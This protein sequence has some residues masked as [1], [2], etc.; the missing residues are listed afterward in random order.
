MNSSSIYCITVSQSFCAYCQQTTL[1]EKNKQLLS[2]LR[3]THD[4]W[5]SLQSHAS[6]SL[7]MLYFSSSSCGIFIRFKPSF[8]RSDWRSMEAAHMRKVKCVGKRWS[9]LG[10][11]FDHCLDTFSNIR[12]FP[13]FARLLWWLGSTWPQQQPIRVQDKLSLSLAT[14]SY[15]LPIH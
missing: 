9:C 15:L 12:T 3:T 5:N 11:T 7:S 4:S 8:H 10:Q 13:W 6:F 14:V 2:L 1:R